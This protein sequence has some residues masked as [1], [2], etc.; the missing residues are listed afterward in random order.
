M[1]VVTRYLFTLWML[2]LAA[3]MATA[4]GPAL[5]AAQQLS[6]QFA[7]MQSMAADFQQQ[8]VDEQGEVLQEASGY[9]RVRRPRQFYWRTTDPYQHLVVANGDTVWI[10][11]IDLEQVSR[12]PF[13]DDL[14]RAPALILSGEAA[15]LVEQYAVDLTREGSGDA[16][17]ETFVLTPR[18]TGGVFSKLQLTFVGGVISAMSLQD[19]FEQVTHIRFS[20]VE[21]NGAIDADLFQFTPPA[22]IDVISNDP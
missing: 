18:Q 16:A 13:N 4:A 7:A 6:R 8:I 1:P 3:A 9:L 5:S 14:D 20:N 17:T 11:D 15:R 21:Y 2:L 12:Q 22:G 19:S 10:Y